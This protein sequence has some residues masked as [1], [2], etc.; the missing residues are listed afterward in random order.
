MKWISLFR[1]IIDFVYFFAFLNAL[2]SP[3]IF[4]L[5]IQDADTAMSIGGHELKNVHWSF[6]LVVLLGIFGYFVFVR[7]LYLMK[8]AA[9]KLKPRALFDAAI[10]S[11]L[12]KAGKNCILAGLLTKIPPFAHSLWGLYAS[13]N[14]RAS[15]FSYTIGFSFDSLFVILSFGFFLMLTAIILQEGLRL[16][17]ENDLTI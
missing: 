14:V 6:Y 8:Q 5:A 3:F 15:K 12:M 4:W 13:I 11:L 10:A 7:M 2:V 9:H 16:K 1:A 17:T